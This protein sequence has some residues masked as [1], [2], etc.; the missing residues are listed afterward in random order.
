MTIRFSST[1]FDLKF[2]LKLF[3]ELLL[4]C[5]KISHSGAPFCC[6]RKQQIQLLQN[7]SRYVDRFLYFSTKSTTL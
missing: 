5:D 1:K 3:L 4:A 6:V 2:D 7:V